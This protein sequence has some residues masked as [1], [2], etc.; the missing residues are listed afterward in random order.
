MPSSRSSNRCEPTRRAA[1]RSLTGL[2]A[3]ALVGCRR[4]EN[5]EAPPDRQEM[6]RQT[7]AIV[8]LPTFVE[9]AE[10]TAALATASAAIDATSLPGVRRL[11]REARAVWDRS[12]A[13]L[14]GPSDDLA[15]TGGAIDSWPAGS[16]ALDALVA[17]T[18]PIDA[19]L[20]GSSAANVRGFP[21][22]EHLL[23]DAVSSDAEAT[24]ALLAEE[25][26]RKLLS[27]Q[28]GDLAA[29]CAALRDGWNAEGGFGHQ[30]AEAGRASTVF[31]TQKD[32]IDKIVTAMIALAERVLVA[33]LVKP[34][35]LDTG[36]AVRPDLEEAPR[37]DGSLAAIEHDLRGLRA[38]YDCELGGRKG[39]S[40]S[41]AVAAISAD[42]DRAVHAALDNALAAVSTVGQPMR[43]A[44]GGD[45][46]ALVALHAAVQTLKRT[47]TTD[48]ASALGA[49]IGFGYSDTD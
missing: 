2:A 26:R 16:A 32:A 7:V 48:M 33:K 18:E 38:V 21:G 11:F 40:L 34:L 20:I 10:K 13:F 43:V 39:D 41:R 25:R 22:M 27:A 8:M 17:G 24:R 4:P 29:K 15:I 35:G 12:E 9:L 46:T 23:F 49:S 5:N 37:S 44:L 36:G 42:A 19:A 6:L 30:L 47:L 3:A 31:A 14:L 28:A 45:R 1:L